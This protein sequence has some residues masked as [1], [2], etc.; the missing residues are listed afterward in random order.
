M[1]AVESALLGHNG[2]DLFLQSS[3]GWRMTNQEEALHSLVN[4][5]NSSPSLAMLSIET[6]I[7]HEQRH[8]VVSRP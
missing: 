1:G 2:P 8:A 6:H 3:K 7:A 4:T 5:Q